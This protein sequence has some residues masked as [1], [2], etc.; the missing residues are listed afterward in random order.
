MELV[1][2]I[3]NEFIFVRVF[4]TEVTFAGSNTNGKYL[5]I[6]TLIDLDKSI[7]NKE[8]IKDEWRQKLS[9]FTTEKEVEKYIIFELESKGLKFIRRRE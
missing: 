8:K 9:E 5:P 1:F 6:T 7:K 4:G 2:S 3:E